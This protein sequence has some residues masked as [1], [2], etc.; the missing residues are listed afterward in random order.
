MDAPPKVQQLVRARHT[1]FFFF[2]HFSFQGTG[3]GWSQYFLFIKFINALIQL[4]SKI[5]FCRDQRIQ[6]HNYTIYVDGLYQIWRSRATNKQTFPKIKSLS[7]KKIYNSKL[8]FVSQIT[9]FEEHKYF[10][11]ET[12]VGPHPEVYSINNYNLIEN[13]NPSLSYLTAK[14]AASRIIKLSFGYHFFIYIRNGPNIISFHP[15]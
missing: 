2:N 12:S 4:C 13:F 11:P 7:R 8:P 5:N 9:R 14:I 15:H 1:F 6:S 3:R 10:P